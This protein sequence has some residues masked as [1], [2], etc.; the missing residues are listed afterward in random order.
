MRKNISDSKLHFFEKYNFGQMRSYLF[1]DNKE[2][3]CGIKMLNLIGQNHQ[4]ICTSVPT[5]MLPFCFCFSGLG[6]PTTTV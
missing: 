3:L 6:S 2:S 5:S 1:K 4:V